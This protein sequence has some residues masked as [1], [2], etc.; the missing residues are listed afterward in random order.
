MTLIIQG[1]HGLP[2]GPQHPVS[3]EIPRGEGLFPLLT[4]HVPQGVPSVGDV[5]NTSQR[6]SPATVFAV[7]VALHAV[8][9]IHLDV[10]L[11]YELGLQLRLVEEGLQALHGRRVV[12]GR[13]HSFGKGSHYA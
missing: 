13:A 10:D 11:G 7:N 2:P 8:F 1:R 5:Q 3:P 6:S 4:H 9:R 12:D